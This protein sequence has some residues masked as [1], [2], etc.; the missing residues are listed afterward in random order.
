MAVAIQAQLQLKLSQASDK[1]F[2][3][4]AFRLLLGSEPNDT[5]ISECLKIFAAW[6]SANPVKQNAAGNARARLLLVHS[7]I[8]HNDF[9]TVR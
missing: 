7:L 9:V 2:I 8:N 6:N 1:E 5:E 3:Q 4:A